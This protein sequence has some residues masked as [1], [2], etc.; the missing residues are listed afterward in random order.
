MRKNISGILKLLCCNRKIYVCHKLSSYMLCYEK[1]ALLY[2]SSFAMKAHKQQQHFRFHAICQTNVCYSRRTHLNTIE[3]L[4]R[5]MRQSEEHIGS[6]E[7]EFSNRVAFFVNCQF[8]KILQHSQSVGLTKLAD[9]GHLESK[10][11]YKSIKL[12]ITN[13]K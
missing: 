11:L 6:P 13:S 12:R 10:A 2:F 5:Q 7:R 1:E 3:F 8:F 4:Q 9:V